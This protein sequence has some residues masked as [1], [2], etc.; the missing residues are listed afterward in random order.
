[1]SPLDDRRVDAPA[2]ERAMS[3]G[4]KARVQNMAAVAQVRFEK[5]RVTRSRISKQLD[6]TIVVS[7]DDCVTVSSHINSVDVSPVAA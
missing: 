6:V 3:V 7:S 4:G 5:L 1:V 2:R